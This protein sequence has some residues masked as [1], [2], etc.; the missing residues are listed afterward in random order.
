MPK[1]AAAKSVVKLKVGW[2]KVRASRGMGIMNPNKI[3]KKLPKKITRKDN[4]DVVDEYKK[5]GPA[6]QRGKK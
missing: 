1:A 2:C 3:G 5:G 6:K 4:P